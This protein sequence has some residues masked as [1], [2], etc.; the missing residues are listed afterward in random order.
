MSHFRSQRGLTFIELMIGLA[1]VA[2]LFAAGIPGF[3]TWLQNSRIRG[4]A[5]AIQN[6]LQLARN[7]AVK[8]NT[9]VRFYLTSSLTASC[10][11]ATNGSDWIISLDD[12][13][14][15]C[16]TAPSENGVVR[17]I[18][19][20]SSSEGSTNVVVA[21]SQVPIIFNGMGRVTPAVAATIPINVTSPSSGVCAA[22]GGPVRCLRVEVSPGGQVRMCDPARAVTDPQGC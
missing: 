4:T 12:P 6:G 2:I 14:G 9:Q 10:T 3:R 17:I 7:E 8:R 13:A 21:A 19:T 1:I 16:D 5:D 20:R 11:A 15:A 18:Q 22:S